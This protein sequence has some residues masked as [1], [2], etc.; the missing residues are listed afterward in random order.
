MIRITDEHFVDIQPQA[1][2]C[3]VETLGAFSNPFTKQLCEQA[4]EDMYQT[5]DTARK[6]SKYKKGDF[7]ITKS[8]D[9]SKFN[10]E[11]I[12]CS[13]IAEPYGRGCSLF[14]LPK[15]M[16]G[17]LKE[18]CAMNLISIAF[19]PLGLKEG[20][21][22]NHVARIM[23]H[24]ANHIHDKIEI[25]FFDPSKVMLPKWKKFLV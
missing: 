25:I 7:I 23:M 17:I 6:L 12:F 11:Y 24:A 4:G 15:I 19:P 3:S 8:F 13:I 14:D 9:L 1:I 5:I 22:A 21:E 2:V 16:E 10:I 20:I 18:A